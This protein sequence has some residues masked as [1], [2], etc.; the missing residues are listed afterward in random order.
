MLEKI[1]SLFGQVDM[2]Q[3]RPWERIV[4]DRKSVV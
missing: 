1:K 4:V 3:G 2:T